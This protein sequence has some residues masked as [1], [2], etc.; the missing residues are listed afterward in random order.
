MGQVLQDNALY[1]T[2]Y[3]WVA[4]ALPADGSWAWVAYF[5]AGMAV[6]MLVVNGLFALTTWYTYAERRIIGRFQSRLGPNRAGPL[7]LLQPI[8]DAIKLLT[9]EDILPRAADRWVF[10][11]A[12]VTMMAPTFLALAVIPFG[13]HSFLANLNIGILYVS[14]VSGI[15]V[16]ALLMA[17]W[18]SANKYAMF[19]SMRAV[20]A[21][22][23]Y[24]IPVVV[25]LLAVV[26][27]TSSFIPAECQENCS[28]MSL[29][30]IVERQALPFLLL[31]PVGFLVF[32]AGISAELNR[33]P[34]DLTEAESE[35]IAGYHTEYSGMKFGTFYLAEFAN[36]LVAGALISVLFLQG[37]RW[38]V[39]PSHLWFLLKVFAVAFAFIW[40]R[41][42]LPRLRIDQVL[43]FAWKFLLPLSLINMVT[44]AVEALVW[45]EPTTSQ[46]WAMIGINWGIAIAA[47]AA[48]SNIISRGPRVPVRTVTAALSPISA[49]NMEVQ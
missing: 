42:T 27:M 16:L 32:V 20:A 21:L 10:N 6:I 47:V 24:E 9:K 13:A 33:S 15:A 34:F 29:V 49:A 8:A 37:W 45:P 39:L 2:V 40:V 3:T 35:I 46:L 4:N 14:A 31:Q 43:A 23:S 19:G 30:A 5:I 38:P 7:G 25:A 17:G 44:V 41:A 11:A 36:V 48:F 28:A 12:P 26:I 22:I 1:R 18:G